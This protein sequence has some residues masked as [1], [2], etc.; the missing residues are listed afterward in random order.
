MVDCGLGLRPTTLF[1]RKPILCYLP[2]L[3]MSNQAFNIFQKHHS[4]SHQF[5]Q[6][7]DWGHQFTQPRDWGVKP[8]KKVVPLD[9]PSLR[10]GPP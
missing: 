10:A 4:S 2:S 8:N 1:L 9:T 5:T 6:P 7:R 3:I